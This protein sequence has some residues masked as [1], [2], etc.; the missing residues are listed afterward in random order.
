MGVMTQLRILRY[1]QRAVLV[2]VGD[3]TQAHDL[4][5]ALRRDRPQGATELVPAAR[6]VLVGYDPAR[7]NHDRLSTDIAGIARTARDP[8][9]I[10]AGGSAIEIPIRY[11]GPDL[12]DVAKMTGLSEPEVVARHLA[13]EYTVAFCGFAPGFGYL[14][15]MDPALRLRRRDIP[16]TRVPAGAVALADEFTG[17]YPRESPGGWHIIGHTGLRIWDVE[18]DPPA[19]LAPGTRVRFSTEVGS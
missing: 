12:A 10:R 3:L 7:T 6:T 2:E 1:G 14:T 8:A 16:R 4:Y 15:G 9:S 13:A 11:D 5:E 19:L 18:R 17:V